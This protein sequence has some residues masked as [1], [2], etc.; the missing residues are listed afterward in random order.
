MR[1]PRFWLVIVL[2]AL[3]AFI[4]QSR[5]D[6]DRIPASQPLSQMPERFGDWT[7]QDIPLT[8]DTLAVLG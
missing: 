7:A 6:A 2:L 4:L 1:S 8:D 3:T 5:G